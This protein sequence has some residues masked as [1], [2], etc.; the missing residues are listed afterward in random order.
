MLNAIGGRWTLPFMALH[1]ADVRRAAEL[2]SNAQA[3]W[4]LTGAG[5]STPSGIP[6]FRGPGGLWERHDAELV[7]S[8]EGLRAHPEAFYAFWMER[9]V[10][11]RETT[12]NAVHRWL[13]KMEREGRLR[14]V[15]TQNIDGLHHAA[16]SVNV[17][18]VHGHVR[19]GSCLS[20][21]RSY[22]F[23][24]VAQQA[25]KHGVARCTCGGLV[26]PDVVLF[27]E[28]L[29]AAMDIAVQAVDGADVLLVMGS[30]LSVWPVAGLV[31]RAYAQGIPVLLANDQPTPY[32][33]GAEVTLRGDLVE[34]CR[35]LEQRVSAGGDRGADG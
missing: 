10:V 3:G 20:C 11:M 32:D 22:G 28:S 1:P 8:I 4:A 26:K 23:E 12:P 13:A 15:I 24:W 17:H 16:G 18:E 7:S 33:D 34:L 9:F 21:G 25:R 14:G 6:D 19:S 30:S 5:V 2:L 35:L 31:P 29:P 27:G